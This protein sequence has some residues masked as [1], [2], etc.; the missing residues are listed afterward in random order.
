[1]FSQGEWSLGNCDRTAQLELVG[2]KLGGAVT[3]VLWGDA[4]NSLSPEKSPRGGGGGPIEGRT[5]QMGAL[6]VILQE[7]K[8][9]LVCLKR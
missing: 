3:R 6:N 9:S 2:G 8:G 5:R 1:V 4:P 7:T